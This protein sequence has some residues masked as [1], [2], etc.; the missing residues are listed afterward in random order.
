MLKSL[1]KGLLIASCLVMPN[2]LVLAQD[3]TAQESGVNYFAK[4]PRLL[5]A[6]T[7]FDAVRF[8]AAKYYFNI[9]LPEDAGNNLQQIGIAQRQGSE[10][11]K[12]KLDETKVFIGNNRRRGEEVAIARVTQLDATGEIKVLLAQPIPPGTDFTVRLK[13]RRNPDYPGIYLF[14]VTAY[15]QGVDPTSLYLGPGRFSFRGGDSSSS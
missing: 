10:D 6:T 1:C 13:P 3:N 9:S 14:G 12:F 4:S 15:P 7:T 2:V 5:G 11:I 8:S